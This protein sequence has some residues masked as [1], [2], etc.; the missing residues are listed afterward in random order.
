M[1]LEQLDNYLFV[2]E[3][4]NLNKVDK[5]LIKDTKQIVKSKNFKKLIPKLKFLDN[6]NIEKLEKKLLEDKEIKNDYNT[7]QRKLKPKSKLESL[8]CLTYASIKKI[9][10]IKGIT[11]TQN[12]LSTLYVAISNLINIGITVGT[13]KFLIECLTRVIYEISFHSPNIAKSITKTHILLG[14]IPWIVLI[15]IVIILYIIKLLVSLFIKILPS[16]NKSDS[17]IEQDKEQE[18]LFK[19][20]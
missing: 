13:I 1:I 9:S 4:N 16:N 2:L 12:I 11:V 19:D 15:T 20:Y 3:N 10:K 8:C 5:N 6:I 7:I 18:D 14:K 17:D